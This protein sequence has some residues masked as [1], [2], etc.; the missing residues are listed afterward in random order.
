MD[1]R[2]RASNVALCAKKK[3]QNQTP[4]PPQ[5]PQKNPASCVFEKYLEFIICVVDSTGIL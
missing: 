5:P 4:Q 2:M 1:T 3:T